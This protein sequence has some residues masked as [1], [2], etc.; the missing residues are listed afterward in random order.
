MILGL[1]IQ[2]YLHLLM[3]ERRTKALKKKKGKKEWTMEE[4]VKGKK[5]AVNGLA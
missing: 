2:H 4:R 1:R 3:G 5:K